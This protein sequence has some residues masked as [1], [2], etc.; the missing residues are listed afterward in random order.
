MFSGAAE[1]GITIS[2]KGVEKYMVAAYC[3]S[4][5]KNESTKL[6]Q[7]SGSL[8]LHHISHGCRQNFSP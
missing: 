6:K 8:L 4:I 3:S 1:Q 7:S 2:N 5:L